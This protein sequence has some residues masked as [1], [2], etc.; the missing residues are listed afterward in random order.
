MKKKVKE[1]NNRNSVFF[2]CNG[3]DKTGNG[4]YDKPF[5]HAY[6]AL[7]KI[8]KKRVNLVHIGKKIYNKCF[9]DLKCPVKKQPPKKR[10]TKKK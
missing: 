10:Q 1:Y 7:S 3:N 8:N 9:E 4:N 5:L 2:S 6:K